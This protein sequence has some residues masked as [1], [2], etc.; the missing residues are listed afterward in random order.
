M[1]SIPSTPY[2]GR[3]DGEDEEGYIEYLRQ[4]VPTLSTEIL[5]RDRDYYFRLLFESELA[6]SG[7]VGILGR[8]LAV[9][10]GELLKRIEGVEYECDTATIAK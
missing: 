8:R 2:V 4:G 6:P 7:L 1:S 9:I 10:G 5:L 3:Y